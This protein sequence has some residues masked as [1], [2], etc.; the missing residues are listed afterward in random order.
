M[1]HGCVQAESRGRAHGTGTPRHCSPL[2]AIS[3]SPTC[4]G[5]GPQTW[6]VLGGGCITQPGIG[7]AAPMAL[8]IAEH[9]APAGQPKPTA[10]GLEGEREWGDRGALPAA[11]GLPKAPELR[12]S[13]SCHGSQLSLCWARNNCCLPAS[14]PGTAP[15]GRCTGG[16][17]PPRPQLAPRGSHPRL[18]TL[19]AFQAGFLTPAPVGTGQVVWLF[20][21]PGFDIFMVFVWLPGR[22]SAPYSKGGLYEGRGNRC[23]LQHSKYCPSVRFSRSF[24][25]RFLMCLWLLLQWIRCLLRA[26]VLFCTW[27]RDELFYF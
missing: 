6:G 7:C 9:P 15:R 4:R 26:V 1:A 3:P 27:T 25:Y 17:R 11:C 8:L 19:T 21:L 18:P 2:P 23:T 5:G 10:L 13:P 20:N 24:C 16:T 22:V 14:P 12:A